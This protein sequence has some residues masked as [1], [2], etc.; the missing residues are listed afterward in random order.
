MRFAGSF[1]SL[2]IELSQVS[3]RC[4]NLRRRGREGIQCHTG[5]TEQTGQTGQTNAN[6]ASKGHHERE[7]GEDAGN[8]AVELQQSPAPPKELCSSPDCLSFL[9]FCPVWSGMSVCFS[10][11]QSLFP[12][13]FSFSFLFFSLSLSLS[14]S[15]SF[16]LFSSQTVDK[17]EAAEET[18]H[19]RST[20]A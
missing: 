6:R 9:S 1:S 15:V 11:S 10:V 2:S 13:L 14:L 12:L 4:R 19:V 3:R 5:Q 16:S 17:L 7:T 20:L 8:A 18:A